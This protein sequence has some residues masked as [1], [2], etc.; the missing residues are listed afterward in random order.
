VREGESGRVYRLGESG[1][2]LLVTLGPGSPPAS[3]AQPPAMVL[4]DIVVVG[5]MLYGTN[6]LDRE[7]VAVDLSGL[8][9]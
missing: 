6:E 9:P 5:D 3:A 2:E 1:P 8:V 4:N 7:L